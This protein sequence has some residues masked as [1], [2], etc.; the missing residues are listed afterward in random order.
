[1]AVEPV[2]ISGNHP[3]AKRRKIPGKVASR[4][5]TGPHPT[6]TV[7]IP[8]GVTIVKKRLGKNGFPPPSSTFVSPGKFVVIW[9]GY[10]PTKSYF[11]DR[12]WANSSSSIYT[13][14]LSV[15]DGLMKSLRFRR[16]LSMEVMSGVLRGAR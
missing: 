9:I 4:T 11:R 13:P 7:I 12:L 14:C 6:P 15:L 1:M 2:N 5:A 8:A 3:V 10:D 16:N